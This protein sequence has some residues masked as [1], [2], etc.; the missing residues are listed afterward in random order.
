MTRITSA[1]ANSIGQ[2]N[3]LAGQIYDA[4]TG[5][6]STGGGAI[7]ATD[8]ITTVNPAT[9]IRFPGGITDGGAGLA[10]QTSWASYVHLYVGGSGIDISQAGRIDVPWDHAQDFTSNPLAALPPTLGITSPLDG[11]SALTVTETGIWGFQFY[12]NGFS[13][14]ATLK[15]Y[16]QGFGAPDV[17]YFINSDIEPMNALGKSGIFFISSGSSIAGSFITTSSAT[18]P[19]YFTT[20]NLVIMRLG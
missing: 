16:M 9:S 20:P 17:E 13:A 6:P 7:S 8:G 14:D 1:S 11:S 10:V 5:D 18:A 12:M 19:T 4:T 3:H 2:H 15:F